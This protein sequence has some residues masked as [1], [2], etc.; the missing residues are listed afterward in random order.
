MELGQG[1][2]T[3]RVAPWVRARLLAG[4][5]GI[6]E[7]ALR[8][9]VD[10]VGVGAQPDLLQAVGRLAAQADDAHLG[11]RVLPGRGRR[12]LGRDVPREVG[13]GDQRGDHRAE[14]DCLHAASSGGATGSRVGIVDL[15]GLRASLHWA[16]GG[17]S[18]CPHCVLAL[19][20]AP[21]LSRGAACPAYA[22][23]VK[24]RLIVLFVVLLLAGGVFLARPLE[25][26]AWARGPRP[27][28]TSREPCSACGR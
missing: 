18:P 15:R 8:I 10:S 20:P 1:W 22:A 21:G 5:D 27:P 23:R 16:I 12:R 28:P 4:Q 17:I 7:C 9:V 25:P 13:R 19:H 2:P 3:L 26:R 6:E 14:V 24:R 11:D